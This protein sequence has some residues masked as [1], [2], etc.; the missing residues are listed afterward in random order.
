[1]APAIFLMPDSPVMKPGKRNG[2][3]H[4]YLRDNKPLGSSS[5]E[6]LMD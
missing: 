5:S 4:S 1:M 2:R 6:P 3:V